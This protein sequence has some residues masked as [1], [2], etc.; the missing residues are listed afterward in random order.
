M[1]DRTGR[2]EI[3]EAPSAKADGFGVKTCCSYLSDPRAKLLRA[4]RRAPLQPSSV[5]SS[6]RF[7]FYLGA[8]LRE[9]HTEISKNLSNVATRQRFQLNNG[10]SRTA[11]LLSQARRQQQ[12]G[13]ASPVG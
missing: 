3:G 12:E 9:P 5:F 2:L 6:R 10:F 11:G 7:R 13:G 4:W 8:C 1:I